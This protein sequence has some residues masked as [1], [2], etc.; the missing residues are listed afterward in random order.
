[1]SSK[2]PVINTS[3]KFSDGMASAHSL[4]IQAKNGIKGN[5]KG[6]RYA[7]P[8]FNVTTFQSINAAVSAA[9]MLG[10]SAILAFS[11][12][13]LKS[14]GLGDQTFGVE[15]TSE[16]VAKLAKRSKIKI[17]THLDH[18]DYI[19]ESGRKV[20]QAAVQGYTSVMADNST[21]HKAERAM[22]L[23]DNIDLTREVVNMA[24]P[25][26]LSVEGELGVLAG[27]EDEDTKSDHSTYTN[28]EELE[29]FV[30]GT[31]VL[32]LAPTIGTMHGPN[33]GKPGH[34]VKLNIEL[35]HQLLKI[36]DSIN[37]EILFVA[38]GAST[39]YPEV[40][41][42]VLKNLSPSHPSVQKWKDFVGTDWDQIQGLIGAGF[43][44][45]NTD[46]ENRQ[47][48]VAA[49]IGALNK[50]SAKIDIRHYDKVTTEALTQSYIK[51]FILAGDYGVW[52][53][54]KIDIN[55]FKFDLSIDLATATG[56]GK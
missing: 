40:V 2:P 27:E 14:F 46:T 24:H 11:N 48:Y 4:L 44:K 35:A 29:Q 6:E 37:P 39:L 38:H 5:Q 17:A 51:K 23:S 8:A 50:D 42:F 31:G 43:A 53:E 49:L 12:S 47:T 32:M 54:P 20:V 34:K 1:M 26:G 13:A 18:G 33:K 52:Y 30:K 22:P 56:T 16:Y 45:I 3:R 19:S 25:L 55:K 15:V 28:P 36:A 41:D 9:E 10:A 21:D 7:I